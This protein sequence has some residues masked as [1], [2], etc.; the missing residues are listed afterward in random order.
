MRRESPTSWLFAASVSLCAL[1]GTLLWGVNVAIVY[2][3]AQIV[4]SLIVAVGR[5]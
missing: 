1:L 4:L 2:L 3:V 5:G